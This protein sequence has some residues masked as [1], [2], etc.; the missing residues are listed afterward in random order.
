VPALGYGQVAANCVWIA[1]LFLAAAAGCRR[2]DGR[3]AHDPAR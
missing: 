3:L 1:L 2:L